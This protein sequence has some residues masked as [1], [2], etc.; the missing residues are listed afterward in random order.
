MF[1]KIA[2]IGDKK[3][4]SGSK[5]FEN[6][7]NEITFNME[8]LLNIALNLFRSLIACICFLLP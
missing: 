6:F 2:C 4:T 1:K 8:A 5:D 7:N 3:R